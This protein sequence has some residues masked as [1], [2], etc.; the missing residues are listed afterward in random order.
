[1]A[2]VGAGSDVG[3]IVSL[4]LKQQKIVKLLALWDE[5]PERG[6][7]GVA[8]DLAHIDT[9]TEV[10]AYQGRMYLKTALYVS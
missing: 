8:T 3:R 9:S 7:L 1:V 4:F 5:C 10:E 2:V 6:V